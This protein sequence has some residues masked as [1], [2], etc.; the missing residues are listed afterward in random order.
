M[1]SLPAS[2]FDGI[3][4]AFASVSTVADLRGFSVAAADLLRRAGWY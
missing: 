1:A 4:S 3:I 2:G